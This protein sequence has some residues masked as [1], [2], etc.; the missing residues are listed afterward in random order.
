MI[1]GGLDENI[2]IGWLDNYK[3]AWLISYL[4]KTNLFGITDHL[5]PQYPYHCTRN[6]NM[7]FY[8]SLSS[9]LSSFVA[10][11]LYFKVTIPM[12]FVTSN[13]MLT[14]KNLIYT[15][16]DVPVKSRSRSLISFTTSKLKS[17][18]I[19]INFILYV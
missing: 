18:I 6:V 12:N 14:Q 8:A 17:K 19:T 4:N 5:S 1:L 9:N 13:V 3:R 7:P 10:I 2:L 11:P 16:V 15:H